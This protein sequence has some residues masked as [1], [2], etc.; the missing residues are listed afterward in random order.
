ML[1][2]LMVAAGFHCE[3]L[4]VCIIKI[5]RQ[6]QAQEPAGLFRSRTS[7][8]RVHCRISPHRT[9]HRL[10]SHSCIGG[11]GLSKL[12]K[13]CTLCANP[14]PMKNHGFDLESRTV[15]ASMCMLHTCS[16]CNNLSQ[17]LFFTSYS[18]WC[19]WFAQ[20]CFQFA[21]SVKITPKSLHS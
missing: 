3:L 9:Q 11:H 18:C 10:Q 12:C 7:I 15:M 1:S 4:G 5:V 19:I 13:L 21:Q 16:H 2:C 14:P 17:F 20:A 8:P 6:T